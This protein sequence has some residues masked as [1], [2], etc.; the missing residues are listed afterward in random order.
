MVESDL[1]IHPSYDGCPDPLA[2]LDEP[3]GKMSEQDEQ[4]FHGYVRGHLIAKSLS[5]PHESYNI[6]PMKAYFNNGKGIKW[7]Q[8]ETKIRKQIEAG[9]STRHRMTV[10]VDYDDENADPRVPISFRVKHQSFENGTWVEHEN[11]EL[12]HEV[13]DPQLGKLTEQTYMNHFNQIELH[14]LVVSGELEKQFSSGEVKLGALDNKASELPSVLRPY[15]PNATKAQGK[16]NQVLNSFMKD[17]SYQKAYQDDELAALKT[18]VEKT[19][20]LPPLGMAY[21]QKVEHRP[22]EEADL[23][24]LSGVLGNLGT[25]LKIKGR[26]SDK[27][28][29]IILQM[30]M[31]RNGGVIKSDDPNDPHQILSKNGTANRPEID[32]IIPRTQ[33]GSNFFSNARVVSWEVNNIIER[34]KETDDLADRKY[35]EANHPEKALNLRIYDVFEKENRPLSDV[36]IAQK[37]QESGFQFNGSPE[38]EVEAAL[39]KMKASG[40][41]E[42]REEDASFDD[43]PRA[44]KRPRTIKKISPVKIASLRRFKVFTLKKRGPYRKERY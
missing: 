27:Q 39:N 22:Y 42:E 2:F 35:I 40:R 12:A 5:G 14:Q 38:K 7:G 16:Y 34:N 23:L 19:G 8:L 32:H 29:E 20:H 26:F 3:N 37:I 1:A 44:W 25:T 31:T 4:D 24:W 30:N 33:G 6:V 10:M 9:K 17:E 21:P 41:V 18:H 28:R 36:E 11:I 15:L 13:D 43:A